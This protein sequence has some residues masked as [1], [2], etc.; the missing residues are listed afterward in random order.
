MDIFCP[1]LHDKGSM[2]FRLVNEVFTIITHFVSLWSFSS[3][4]RLS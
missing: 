2:N 1:Q 3:R 4:S